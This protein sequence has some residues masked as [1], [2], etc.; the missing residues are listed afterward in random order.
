MGEHDSTHSACASSDWLWINLQRGGDFLHRVTLDHVADLQVR[1]ILQSQAALSAGFDFLHIVLEMFQAADA[2]LELYRL[3]PQHAHAARAR[4]TSGRHDTAGD[5]WPF[6]KLEELAH[7]GV[8]DDSL[9]RLGLE[10][11]FH[12]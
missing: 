6:S 12:G 9:L 10:H 1:K 7:F 5:Q 2:A 11:A 4:D 3:A 8:A